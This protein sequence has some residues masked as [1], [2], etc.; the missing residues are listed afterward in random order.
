MKTRLPTQDYGNFFY[1]EP[2]FR[3]ATNR[4]QQKATPCERTFARV[5]LDRDFYIIKKKIAFLFPASLRCRAI[6]ARHRMSPR[7]RI[8]AKKHAAR[9][10]EGA[11]DVI[12]PLGQSCGFAHDTISRPLSAIE[13]SPI[14][15]ADA[16]DISARQRIC[17]VSRTRVIEVRVTH[18]FRSR[19]EKVEKVHVQLHFTP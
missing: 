6:I 4:R 5:H 18:F 3:S 15:S 7:P 11:C 14:A 1:T 16:S 13:K 19:D 9:R 2:D 17:V 12:A 8:C 10:I